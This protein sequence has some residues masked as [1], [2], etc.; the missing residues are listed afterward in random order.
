M[1]NYYWL[2]VYDAVPVMDNS[3]PG[4]PSTIGIR[5]QVDPSIPL[6]ASPVNCGRSFLLMQPGALAAKFQNEVADAILDIME[7]MP[8]DEKRKLFGSEY[9]WDMLK[10]RTGSEIMDIYSRW[11]NKK[12]QE[13]NA[14]IQAAIELLRSNGYTVT[15]KAVQ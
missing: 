7:N 5:I 15:E 14:Q 2:K 12:K 10:R 8:S 11:K 3:G 9:S 4:A 13:A 6:Y 1:E